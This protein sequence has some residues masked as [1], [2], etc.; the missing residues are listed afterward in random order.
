MERIPVFKNTFCK[1]CLALLVSR[2][3]QSVMLLPDVLSF[4]R[5]I[6]AAATALR[7][8]QT[9][10][11]FEGFFFLCL[12]FVYSL[13]LSESFLFQVSIFSLASESIVFAYSCLETSRYS[14]VAFL[15][16]LQF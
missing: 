1:R 10:A 3:A 16:R 12:F 6:S 4:G 2:V 13:S 15:C 9:F 8:H 14:E 7:C 5:F 11:A